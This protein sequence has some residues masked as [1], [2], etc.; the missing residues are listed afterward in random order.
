[1][2]TLVRKSLKIS[3]WHRT[4]ST[5]GVVFDIDGVITQGSR[6][7]PTAPSALQKLK[8]ANIPHLF[9]T[10]GGGMRESYKS[11]QLSQWLQVPVFPDDVVLGHTPMKQLVPEFE[12]RNIVCL[13]WGNPKDVLES[14]ALE[15]LS[16]FVHVAQVW[17]QESDFQ[18]RVWRIASVLAS[19]YQI[20]A[21]EN[22]HQSR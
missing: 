13:G 22:P 7:I 6:V 11:N 17:F 15:F 20:W 19:F 18:R 4:V 10:N 12:N 21:T 1:M 3:C 16:V 8:R 2:F 5:Y 9:I 14:Y